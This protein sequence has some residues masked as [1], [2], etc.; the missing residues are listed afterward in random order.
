MANSINIDSPRYD[1]SSYIGRA[2]HFI[3]TTNPLN[4]LATSAELE[5]SKEIVETFRLTKTLPSDLSENELWKA[6]Y[7]MDSAYHPDTKEKMFFLG[8]MSAQVPANL[9]I[10]AG[11]LT[12]YKT[13]PG[14]VFWQ[15]L[16]QSFN[17]VVNYTNRSGDAPIPASRLATS[18]TIATTSATATA[19]FLGKVA[20][21]MP[22]IFGRCVPFAAVAA[23]NCINLPF[24]RSS[25]IL[26]G[27][28]LVN[29]DDEKIAKS[30]K[31][32]KSAIAQVVLS[33]VFMATPGMILVPVAMSRIE[34][35]FPKVK[36]SIVQTLA[37][38]LLF[39]GTC[40]VFAT[41]LCCAIFPQKSSVQIQKL[42]EPVKAKLLKDGY[43][44]SEFVYYN[45]GL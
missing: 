43:K 30:P 23:A 26:E 40:L 6:K 25:E 34:N 4:I 3:V 14:T 13:I 45:K 10:T 38:Q 12:F 36:T 7:L 8:R 17:A 24:M 21:K 16:N 19:I 27:I 5:K 39:V 42:E 32:A 11:M 33:R 44:P 37:L 22:P 41:P 35:K 15:V 9:V 20:K 1:Q 18:F 29:G 31:V 2:K 28:Q